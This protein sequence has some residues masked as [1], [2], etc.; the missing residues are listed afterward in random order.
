MPQSPGAKPRGILHTSSRDET[1]QLSRYLP[2]QDLSFFI[3]HY[4]IVSW[5]L[6]GCEPYIQE[7][8]PYP[9]VHLV[10]EQGASQVYGVQTGKFTRTLANQG[11][12]FGMK[13]KP[14]AFYPFVRTPVSR[15]TN[16][17]ATLCDALHVDS[18]PLEDAILSRDDEGEMLVLAENFLRQ[19]LPE[20][21]PHVTLI[22]DIVDWIS[23]HREIT[24]VDDIAVRFHLNKRAMQRLFR[25][26]VGVSPKWVVQRFRLHE[27]AER[28]AVGEAV[29]WPTI[30]AELGYSDQAHVIKDFKAIVGQTPAA[31]AKS[32]SDP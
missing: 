24:K 21:D 26:Y 11:R 18:A 29:D 7:T 14:G 8:L 30:V 16:T 12:V 6:Q 32:L 3:E 4:W 13:F 27:V 25:Q 22:N 31:Y 17:T 28:L 1:F 15:F 20:H 10:V 5:D 2:A 9:S 19:L 23:A